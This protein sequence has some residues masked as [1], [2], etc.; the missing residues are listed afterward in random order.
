MHNYLNYAGRYVIND[1]S[2]HTAFNP[3]IL[4]ASKNLGMAMVYT[5]VTSAKEWLSERF[6]QEDDIDN[7]E[8]D[9]NAKVEVWLF[10]PD[11]NMF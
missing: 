7:T 8:E 3:Y 10:W 11:F 6:S 9:E 4:Q 1:S 5:L 2:R